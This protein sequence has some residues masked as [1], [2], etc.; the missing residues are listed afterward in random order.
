MQPR[1]ARKFLTLIT[2]P[3]LD[4]VWELQESS[5][6]QDGRCYHGYKVKRIDLGVWRLGNQIDHSHER[7]KYWFSL[8]HLFGHTFMGG[9]TVYVFT[10]C[11]HHLL[12]LLVLNEQTVRGEPNTIKVQ[13]DLEKEGLVVG[14]LLVYDQGMQGMVKGKKELDS[15]VGQSWSHMRCDHSKC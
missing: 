15:K 13:E 14:A 7:Q 10:Y 9:S 1:S 8:I 2:G 4:L 11:I 6:Q 5:I 3:K 12:W